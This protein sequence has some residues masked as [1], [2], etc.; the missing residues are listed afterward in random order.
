MDTTATSTG[1]KPRHSSNGNSE[2]IKAG[3][4]ETRSQMDET[5]DALS[6]RLQPR[7]LLDDI[8]DYFKSRRSTG[9]GHT[10]EQMKHAAGNVKAAAGNMSRK[11]AGQVRDHPIPTLLIGAGIAWL[12]MENE[13]RGRADQGYPEEWTDGME[14][15]Y[16]SAVAGY[17]VTETT[18]YEAAPSPESF[19][20]PSHYEAGDY[21]SSSGIKGRMREKGSRMKERGAEWKQRAG[22][23]LHRARERTSEKTE[24]MRQAARER[25]MRLREQARHG[26]EQGVD[27][28]KHASDEHPLAMGVG[29]LALGVL[30]GML[31]PVTSKEQQLVG[32]TRDRLV[33]RTREAAEDAM[34]RGKQVMHTAVDAAKSEVEK[35]GLTPDALKAK[36]TSVMERVKTVAREEGL[37][38][39]GLKGKAKAVAEHTKQTTQQEVRTQTEEMKQNV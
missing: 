18:E 39:E 12:I 36:G 29:F 20:L 3:I 5:L 23:S 11:V 7:H 9:D 28:F 38:P 25:A 13:R 2:E 27:S 24:A 4:E 1:M 30:A 17:V 37:T 32:P 22:D 16:D 15:D 14:E 31:L 6:E 19:A 8:L 34:H 26:Y 35:Q 33:R 10:S 21:G